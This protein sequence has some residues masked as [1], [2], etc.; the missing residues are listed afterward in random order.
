MN[1]K[2]MR[3]FKLIPPIYKLPGAS[4]D[5]PK[6][7][8]RMGLQLKFFYRSSDGMKYQIVY[9]TCVYAASQKAFEKKSIKLYK[10]CQDYFSRTTIHDWVQNTGVKV[11]KVEEP[12][13]IPNDTEVVKEPKTKTNGSKRTKK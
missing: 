7:C 13:V 6:G 1:K 5:A 10:E 8:E 12:K 9:D 11:F 2:K 3:T 4:T